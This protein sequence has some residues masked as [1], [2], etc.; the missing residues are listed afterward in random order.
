MATGETNSGGLIVISS[1][2]GAVLNST[3][4]RVRRFVHDSESVVKKFQDMTVIVWGQLAREAAGVELG[5]LIL[6]KDPRG[7]VGDLSTVDVQRIMRAP[8]S[9]R[10]DGILPPFA[11]FTIAHDG[12]CE[13]ST[14]R[15]GFRQIYTHE[16][17]WV[18]FG[19]S[20]VVMGRLTG[21][22]LDLDT[23]ATQ[24]LLGW[25][26][27]S[28]SIF[29]GVNVLA[30]GGTASVSA[31]V[32]RIHT[33]CAQ[34]IP[35]G[36]ADPSESVISAAKLLR[37][38]LNAYLDDHPSAVLQLTGG[39]DS[40]ILL[41]AIPVSRR[42]SVAATTLRV[43]GSE[44][45]PLAAQ[46][47]ERYGMRHQVATLE[48]LAEL[49][50]VEAFE[51]CLTAA[52]RLDCGADPLGFGAL[53]NAESRMPLGERLAGLGGEYARGF[54][55]FGRLGTSPVTRKKVA[56]LARWR[57]FT[58]E[59]VA[60]QA[61]DPEFRDNAERLAVDAIYCCF[62][63]TGVAWPKVTDE[64]YLHQRMRRWAGVLATASC[65]E[66][67]VLNPMLDDRFL[68]LVRTVSPAAKKNAAFL[69]QLL[70]ELDPE[71]AALPLD[72]RPPPA[73]IVRPGIAGNMRLASGLMRKVTRKVA[74]RVYRTERPPV[75][76]EV[77]CA[78]I[79]EYWR[80]Q[81]ELL[82]RLVDIGVFRAEWLEM[83]AMGVEMPSSSSVSLMVN[84][85]AATSA[86]PATEG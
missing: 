81:P 33:A 80:Q 47:A 83:V 64:F 71:L 77:L 74:Q 36:D 31:G 46:I 30:A 67:G 35:H 54:Y 52:R 73:V 72:G 41:A 20:A 8:A 18:G 49:A 61:L 11:A 63:E 82:E 39:L 59:A 5:T 53:I 70:I 57:M 60:R 58:N 65:M 23:L 78:G 1:L 24:S 9:G 85:L 29:S 2:D 79:V 13:V 14:D 75:G 66:R 28:G 17:T 68:S 22:Q 21:G 51:L 15:L 16:G 48:A 37:E 84:L 50:P 55:Y 38:W 45:A 7:P 32:L 25:Q 4:D 12:A 27:G 44:D 19:T 56:N 3:V 86:G 10:T 76:A 69:S 34:P 6:S 42:P 43:T 62:V 40:R 26:V